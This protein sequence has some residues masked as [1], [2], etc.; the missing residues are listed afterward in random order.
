MG[1]H[2]YIQRTRDALLDSISCLPIRSAA[3]F[4]SECCF[5]DPNDVCTC[6]NHHCFTSN[7][8]GR[9]DHSCEL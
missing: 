7:I 5:H 3:V 9:A 2:A 1:R 8:V 6:L 4:Q